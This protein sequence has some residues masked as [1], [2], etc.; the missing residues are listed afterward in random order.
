[1]PGSQQH[2]CS[3]SFTPTMS[4]DKCPNTV[5]HCRNRLA[6]GMSDMS[7][8]L[9]FLL[10]EIVSLGHSGQVPLGSPDGVLMASVEIC[11]GPCSALGGLGFH[12][13]P[14]V[15][16]LDFLCFFLQ[17]L[18]TSWFFFFLPSYTP[19]YTCFFVL[20]TMYPRNDSVSVH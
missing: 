13:L 18:P 11:R 15:S 20:R 2:Q 14:L 8:V 6:M 16:S 19:C 17:T 3:R 4:K 1:M 9:G 7:A 5:A 10:T 12:P